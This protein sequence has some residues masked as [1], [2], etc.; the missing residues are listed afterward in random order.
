MGDVTI[1]NDKSS[2]VADL[3]KERNSA[4]VIALNPGSYRVVKNKRRNTRT[5][6]CFGKRTLYNTP[7]KSGVFF[8]PIILKWKKGQ[9]GEQIHS[10]RCKPFYRL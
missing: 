1:F 9:L 8:N 10:N 7:Y 3:V 4:I 6:L 5:G 2:V